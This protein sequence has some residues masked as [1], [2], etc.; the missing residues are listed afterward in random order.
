MRSLFLLGHHP[1]CSPSN[2]GLEQSE[3]KQ[4]RAGMAVSRV[5]QGRAH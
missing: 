1:S 3:G 2:T 5:Y 4:R